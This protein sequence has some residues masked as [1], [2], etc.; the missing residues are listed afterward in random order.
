MYNKSASAF[1]LGRHLAL[2][3]LSLGWL[4]VQPPASGCLYRIPELL[5]YT[6]Q[7]LVLSLTCFDSRVWLNLMAGLI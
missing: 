5:V 1:A 3:L 2:L 4:Q 7:L 6:G